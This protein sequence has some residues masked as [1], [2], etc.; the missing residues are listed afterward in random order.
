MKVR[1]IDETYMVG[2]NLDKHYDN[3]VAKD[4]ADF[5][6]YEHTPNKKF[7]YM[8]KRDY[9]KRGNELSK[10][11]VYSSELSDS[12]DVIGYYNI[13]GRIVKYRKSTGELIAYKATK[14]D[15]ATISYYLTLGEEDG[16]SSYKRKKKRDYLRELMPEDDKYT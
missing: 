11:R 5:E 3:H 2:K 16:H 9:N 8:T 1:V 13:D 10:Q 15:Q 7:A 14:D 4:D 12:H 6:K